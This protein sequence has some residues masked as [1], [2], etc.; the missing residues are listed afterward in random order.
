MYAPSVLSCVNS[1]LHSNVAGATEDEGDEG[2]K[3][4]DGDAVTSPTTVGRNWLACPRSEYRGYR[5]ARGA[6]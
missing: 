4:E 2:D 5:G 6:R 3:G 1:T